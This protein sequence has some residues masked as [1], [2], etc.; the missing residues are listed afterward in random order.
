MY[1]LRLGGRW[2]DLARTARDKNKAELFGEFHEQRGMT[3][4]E[5]ADTKEGPTPWERFMS[6]ARKVTQT[7]KTE[8][9]RREAVMISPVLVGGPWRVPA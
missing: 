1:E 5:K 6:L 2:R 9:E 4:P 3:Q 8:V 7:P